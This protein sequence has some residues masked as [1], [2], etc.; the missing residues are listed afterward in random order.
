M[1]TRRTPTHRL[2]Q[3]W[4]KRA[5]KIRQDLAV[6]SDLHRFERAHGES[7]GLFR[8]NILILSVGFGDYPA[9]P[10][11]TAFQR[12]G[13]KGWHDAGAKALALRPNS[14]WDGYSS[15]P[16]N[17]A[18]QL[19]EDLVFTAQ[20]GKGKEWRGELL[21]QPTRVYFLCRVERYT[22]RQPG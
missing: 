7:R 10:N 20:H 9:L 21:A 16:Y 19:A 17:T 12:N 22:C 3:S 11:E 5:R 2:R 15:A 18:T 13:W 8:G 6:L 14:L 4:S 1:R